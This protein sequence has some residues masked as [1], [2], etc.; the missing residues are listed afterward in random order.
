VHCGIV[1]VTVPIAASCV[2]LAAWLARWRGWPTA[3]DLR[4]TLLFALS[5]AALLSVPT[6]QNH[7]RSG[8]FVLA[9]YGGGPNFYIGNNENADGGYAHLRPDRSDPAVEES[10]AILL[11]NSASGKRLSPAA[12]SRY[13]WQQGFAFWRAHPDQARRLVTKK[14]VLIWGSQEIADG[15]RPASPRAG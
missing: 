2:L 9:A 5:I 10:D 3:P 15:C 11:T 7:A 12:V 1:E 14:W 13:W 4:S 8:D 6:M